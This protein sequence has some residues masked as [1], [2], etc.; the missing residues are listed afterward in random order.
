MSNNVDLTFDN[1]IVLQN[2]QREGI[3]GGV[4][5]GGGEPGELLYKD[6][7]GWQPCVDYC[8]QNSISYGRV[9]GSGF[10]S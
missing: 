8:Q 6:D 7:R 1:E 2:I 4:S 5:H 10:A 3:C 9:W